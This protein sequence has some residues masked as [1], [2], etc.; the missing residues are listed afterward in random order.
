[1]SEQTVQFLLNNGVAVLVLVATGWGIYLL[2]RSAIKGI[3]HAFEHVVV[4]VKD[5]A[6]KHIEATNKH[7]ERTGE[8]ISGLQCTL[9]KI[10]RKLPSK[11]HE[12]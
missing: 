5:A 1:M 10:D 12:S 6:V 9:E 8:A 11:S 2:A 4:P 3:G 7:L